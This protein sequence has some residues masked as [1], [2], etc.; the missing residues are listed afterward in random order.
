MPG[1]RLE[2]VRPLMSGDFEFDGNFRTQLVSTPHLP[3]LFGARY[4]QNMT[5]LLPPPNCAEFA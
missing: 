5:N 4:D 2:L 3:H 1:T